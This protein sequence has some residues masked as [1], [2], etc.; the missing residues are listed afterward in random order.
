MSDLR[1][2]LSLDPEWRV[3]L[4]HAD[5]YVR[6]DIPP[7]YCG[8]SDLAREHGLRFRAFLDG[9]TEDGVGVF[10]I[11]SADFPSVV[12]YTTNYEGWPAED[13]VPR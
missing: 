1:F 2:D 7:D 6:F 10:G 5:A 4:F 9:R 3:R 13:T 12:M 8:I 11:E